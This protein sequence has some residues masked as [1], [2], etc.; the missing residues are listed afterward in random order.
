MILSPNPKRRSCKLPKIVPD[1]TDSYRS[2]GITRTSESTIIHNK[3]SCISYIKNLS[4]FNRY[5]I[6]RKY[7]SYLKEKKHTSIRLDQ[8]HDKIKGINDLQKKYHLKF[9]NKEIRL[10]NIDRLE[11][12]AKEKH[13]KKLKNSASIKIARWW[14]R[15]FIVKKLA[16]QQKL[17][18][19]AAIRIQKAWKKYVKEK[20]IRISIELLLSKY[21]RASVVIQRYYRGY[22]IRRKYGLMIKE[23]KMQTNFRYFQN[24]R[25]KLYKES[26]S[27][28]KRSWIAYQA[29]KKL[30]LHKRNKRKQ[31][32]TILTDPPSCKNSVARDI[33]FLFVNANPNEAANKA[34]SEPESPLLYGNRLRTGPI[35]FIRLTVKSVERRP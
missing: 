26:S 17:L 9:N 11:T 29:R 20:N 25:D 3:S 12:I 28:I 34:K 15:I 16:K 2:Q 4:S 13:L 27:I 6:E 7:H 5:D 30:S 10:F 1:H 24:I 19:N 21:N 14:K 18:E 33:K 32:Y 22:Q 8:I 35:D 23:R 31:V